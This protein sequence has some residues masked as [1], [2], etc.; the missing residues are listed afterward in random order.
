MLIIDVMQITMTSLM[1]SLEVKRSPILRAGENLGY[2]RTYYFF[3]DTVQG[4]KGNKHSATCREDPKEV[5]K[6]HKLY[7]YFVDYVLTPHDQNGFSTKSAKIGIFH[8]FLC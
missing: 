7:I 8:F 6:C 1:T 5:F 2:L 3:S 4:D